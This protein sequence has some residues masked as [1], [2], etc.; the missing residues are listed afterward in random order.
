M[1]NKYGVALRDFCAF[2]RLK[3]TNSFYGHKD[4][5]RFIREARGTRS[6]INCIIINGKLKSN[7][8][9]IRVLRGSKNNSDH[10]LVESKFKFLTHAKQSYNKTDKTIYKN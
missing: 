5:H 10:K 8:E 2:N 1:E 7:N 4:I 3:I 9:D 6:I